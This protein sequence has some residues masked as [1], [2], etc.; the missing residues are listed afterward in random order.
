[1]ITLKLLRDSLKIGKP[2]HYLYYVG[3]NYY[4][5]ANT[6]REA[7]QLFIPPY[8]QEQLNLNMSCDPSLFSAL[9]SGKTDTSRHS[10]ESRRRKFYSLMLDTNFFY[11]EIED[12]CKQLIILNAQI[13]DYKRNHKS[14]ND[15]SI[16]TELC[17]KGTPSYEKAI[18][19]VIQDLQASFMISLKQN[20][21]DD[22]RLSQKLKNYIIEMVDKDFEVALSW[23]IIT[24]IWSDS[25]E[26]Y[27]E[28]GEIEK[29]Y[30]CGNKQ[31][32]N[33][34]S[35]WNL[36]EEL[37]TDLSSK[38]TNAILNCDYKWGPYSDDKTIQNA[39][40]CEGGLALCAI[41]FEFED[42]YKKFIMD[43]FYY[44]GTQKNELGIPSKS[45]KER[46]VVPTSMY[47]YFASCLKKFNW[48]D[49]N[50]WEEACHMAQ[51]LWNI[52]NEDGWGIYIMQ[53]SNNVCNIGCSYW[54]LRAIGEYK[55]VV[56]EITYNEFIK[57]LFRYQKTNLFG[58]SL[59][60]TL[61]NM[62]RTKLYATAMMLHLYFLC[63]SKT[64][65]EIDKK[66]DY[67]EALDYIQK[68]FDV[69]EYISE[70]EEI[71]G[72]D[73]IETE[74]I[75]YVN[76]T[77]ITLRYCIDAIAESIRLGKLKEI[78]IDI[79]LGRLCKIIKNNIYEKSVL[80]YWVDRNKIF[81]KEGR[82][83]LIFPT[84]HILMG[85]ANLKN[86][87]ITINQSKREENRNESGY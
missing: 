54:A 71:E 81:E 30:L 32:E 60:A 74:S 79:F 59:N 64:Q 70:T 41:Q 9:F 43:A 15:I 49:D 8:I 29:K 87:L 56:D 14:I 28:I 63:N 86:V 73:A 77:H 19:N 1:M 82:G 78:E 45:L 27:H 35:N 52:R 47:L 26:N 55:G 75:H 44:L 5:P 22:Q 80:A 53:H 2:G 76:W 83:Y 40:V 39:N 84:M 7:W 33:F 66:F 24:A 23:M 10:A 67:R 36:F 3:Q 13:D 6:L 46:T 42:E 72:T 58:S 37:Y 21:L 57:S 18:R 4:K 51:N 16:Q 85:L 65:G 62:G 68:N 50:D 17:Y 38:F 61:R 20:L 69:Q 31:K 48:I 12:Y 34:Q 11:E 25:L